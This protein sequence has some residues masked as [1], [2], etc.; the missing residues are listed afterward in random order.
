MAVSSVTAIRSVA[1]CFVILLVEFDALFSNLFTESRNPARPAQLHWNQRSCHESWFTFDLLD[2]DWFVLNSRVDGFVHQSDW[3]IK[4]RSFSFL[5]LICLNDLCFPLSCWRWLSFQTQLGY[6]K[7]GAI[8]LWRARN[9]LFMQLSWMDCSGRSESDVRE[10]PD[11][12]FTAAR[13][14]AALFYVQ[15]S[16]HFSSS[17]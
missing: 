11:K 5:Q 17:D 2:A 6:R 7:N 13:N 16:V 15:N 8:C 9:D 1:H 14:T 10:E 4:T 12:T 3:T